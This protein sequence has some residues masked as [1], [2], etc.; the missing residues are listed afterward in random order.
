MSWAGG[1]L[2]M[3][4]RGECRADAVVAGDRFSSLDG[5][6]KAEGLFEDMELMPHHIYFYFYLAQPLYHTWRY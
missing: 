1:V 5:K 3:G 6:G 4:P 2:G